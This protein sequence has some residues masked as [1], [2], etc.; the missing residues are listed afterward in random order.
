[1]NNGLYP[2]ASPGQSYSM[3]AGL[4][5]PNG[6]VI[7]GTALC[8]EAG[9][10]S[11]VA[12]SSNVP[13][14]GAPVTTITVSLKNSTGPIAGASVELTQTT[15]SGSTGGATVSPAVGTTSA[16]GVATFTVSDTN[17]QKVTY[18]AKDV[19]SG[20]TVLQ[21]ATVSFDG[22]PYVPLPPARICDT[23]PNNP[24]GLS[25]AALS[26]CE[27][28]ALHPNSYLTIQVAGLAGD[29][30]PVGAVG[31]A[32]NVTAIGATQP[33]YL[34]VYPAS[35]S[36]RPIASSINAFTGVTVANL[37]VVDLPAAGSHA[38]EVTIYNLGG[39]VNV[40]VDVE[41][42]YIAS[43]TTQGSSQGSTQASL[44]TP[45][46][47]PQRLV[48][49]R[50]SIAS[51]LLMNA[52]YC[53]AI[54]TANSHLTGFQAGQVQAIK[55]T[56]LSGIPASGASAVV[57]NVTAAAATGGG[58]FTLYPTG[59]TRPTASNLN[60][61]AGNAVA[62]RVIVPVG[63]NGDVDLYASG[64]AQA[65]VDISGYLSTS[66][67]GSPGVTLSPVRIC[68]TRPGNPSKLSGAQAQCN[69]NTLSP[70]SQITI[71]VEGVGGL[72][73]SGI[74]AVM[75][76]LTAANAGSSGYLSVNPASR[77]PTTSDVNWT[78]AEKI[79]VPNLVL[80]S[81]NASGDMIV[82]NGAGQSKVNIIVDVVGY[83]AG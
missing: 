46:G 47:S 35:D 43:S 61:K 50:C 45:L 53:S 32:L 27:G 2:A 30:V 41:G 19:S 72:P 17:I 48:D 9:T 58:Y 51:Y 28:H 63:S 23:R 52:G 16:S 77:P 37:L 55:V 57:L 64:A 15:S 33:T 4:G 5:T 8:G 80:A 21:T 62:N 82:Y 3:A 10:S 56:G 18:S 44:Y 31:V 71:K 59:T 83:M 25:G 13:A 69:N 39:T 38:G 20:T 66:G 1:M 6:A 74:S 81:V 79:A 7:A 67:S 68:D 14:S 73:S 76:N 36:S 75:I 49:T 65:V 12:A 26:Q 70:L 24:S 34:T 22:S 40:T 29:D 60:W 11:V 54:P 42:Y 78:G